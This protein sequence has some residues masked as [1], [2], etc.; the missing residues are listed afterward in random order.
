MPYIFII[1]EIYIERLNLLLQKIHAKICGCPMLK[2]A[3]FLL[4]S[5]LIPN[6]F[7]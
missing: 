1:A 4:A 7:F 6:D 5:F 3:C 2:S